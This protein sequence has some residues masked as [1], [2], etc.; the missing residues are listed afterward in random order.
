VSPLVVQFLMLM[1]L[2]V[3]SLLVVAIFRRARRT[4]TSMARLRSSPTPAR[5][6]PAGPARWAAGLPVNAAPTSPRGLPPAPPARGPDELIAP[7]LTTD[8][9]DTVRNWL[10]HHSRRD[11]TWGHVVTAFYQRAAA[12]PQIASYFVGVDMERLQRHFVATLVMITSRGLTAG[13]VRAM[14]LA[15][16]SIRDTAG[17]PITG[18]V[19]DKV[20][21]TL[22]TILA[23]NG[24]PADAI[25]DLAGL[26]APLRS[27]IVATEHIP[28][29]RTG[30]TRP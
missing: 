14:T 21:T 10:R 2:G 23:E 6:R 29:N 13:A 16:G 30:G 8:E 25:N 1:W 17:H 4:R 5:P 3:L 19:Y 9:G 7:P 26:V 20:I 15:H 28:P 27:A 11:L 22:V 12:D 24:V 18:E